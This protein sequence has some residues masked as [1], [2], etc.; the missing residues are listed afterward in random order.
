MTVAELIQQYRRHAEQ[1]YRGPDGKRTCEVE[2]VRKAC[3]IVRTL[4]GDSLAKDFGPLALQAVRGVFIDKGYCRTSINRDI[5]RIKL[6]FKWG[7][8]RELLPPSVFQG[9]ATVGGLRIGRSGAKESE[10]VKPVPQAFIDAALQHV[11]PT[12]AALINLQLLT[13]ARPGELL[14]MRTCDLDMSGRIWTFTPASHKNAHRGHRRTIYLGPQ[15]QAV[16]QPFL[17]TDLQAFIFSPRE[18]VAGLRMARRAARKTPLS[19]ENVPGSNCIR[20]TDYPPIFVP[21]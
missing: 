14:S 3:R 11:P 18:A 20:R 7:V 10:P 13:A 8:S 6:M 17:K 12:V 16:V 15:A 2:N 5:G 9:L 19:C 21:V 4:Y 1:Y